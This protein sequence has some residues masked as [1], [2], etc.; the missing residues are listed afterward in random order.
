[1]PGA[2]YHVTAHAVAREPLFRD[3]ADR[4]HFLGILEEVVARHDWS[5]H[6]FCLMTTHYHLLVRTPNPDIGVGMQ[7]LNGHYAARFNKRHGIV[8]HVFNRRYHS[9]LVERESHLLDLC[10]YF[11]LNPV[12]AG[13]CSRPADWRWGSYAAVLGVARRPPFLAVEWLLAHFGSNLERAR[14]RF[15][16]FVED[17]PAAATTQFRYGV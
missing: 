9:L 14:E 16:A 15:R 2:A 4:T 17:A 3:D 6:A 11:A 12:R 7:R 8:G 1:M 5:C 13:A 10:R